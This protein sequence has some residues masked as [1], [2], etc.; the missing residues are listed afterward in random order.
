[1]MILFYPVFLIQIIPA[2]K[3]PDSKVHGTN[4]GHIW[5]RQDQGEPHVAP[6]NFAIWDG[7]YRMI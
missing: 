6:M 1:M 5:G 7:M 2:W 3:I 4:M